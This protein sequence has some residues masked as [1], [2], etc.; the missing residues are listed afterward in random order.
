MA[1]GRRG[2]TDVTLGAGHVAGIFLGFVV[3]CGI[4]FTLGYVLGRGHSPPAAAGKTKPATVDAN[5]NLAGGQGSP[6]P[7]GWDFYPKKNGRAGGSP[8]NATPGLTP[9]P[10]AGSEAAPH[11]ADPSP[12]SGPV[13]MSPKPARLKVEPKPPALPGGKGGI[14]LQVAALT[15]KADAL[16]LAGFLKQKGYPAFAWGP[17]S[18]HLFRVQVGPYPSAKTAEAAKKKLEHEG[19]KSILKK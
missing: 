2:Q 11:S 14:S 4:F 3:L 8:A 6:A 12:N 19:F 7:T 9:S 17:A 1:S 15:D 13:A 5:G 18:D 16:A 10:S